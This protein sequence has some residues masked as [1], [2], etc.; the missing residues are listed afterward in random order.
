MYVGTL[1]TTGAAGSD[2]THF[3]W[4]YGVTAVNGKIY[5][6]DLGNN[7]VQ[8]FNAATYAYLATIGGTEGTGS[9]QLQSPIDVAVDSSGTIYVTDIGN[10]RVQVFN[11]SNSLLACNKN[12]SF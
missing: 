6:A 3:S 7:R 12:E 2:N 5:V 11:S 4:P 1:G 10:E 9:K 8:I